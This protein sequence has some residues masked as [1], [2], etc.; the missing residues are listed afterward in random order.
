MEMD[1]ENQA[2]V[3]LS[4]INKNR[5]YTVRKKEPKTG[6]ASATR[7]P[8]F[9]GLYRINCVSPEKIRYE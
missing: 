3:M 7:T 8:L 2:L 6:G 9:S 5:T 4:W 1:L